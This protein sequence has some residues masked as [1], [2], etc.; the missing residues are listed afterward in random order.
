MKKLYQGLLTMGLVL[1]MA[2]VSLAASA[3]PS[4]AKVMV[5][6]QVVPF[7]AYE[8][9]GFNYFKLTDMSY[10]LTGTKNQ[11]QVTWDGA[12]S[13]INMVSNEPHLVLGTELQG[14]SGKAENAE[15]LG[16][17]VYQDGKAVDCVVYSINGSSYFQLDTL[18]GILD[19]NVGWNGTT[20][21]ITI[22]A[23][24]L[25]SYT[26]TGDTNGDG[27]ISTAEVNAVFTRFRSQYP[28]GTNW[29]NSNS[30][31]TTRRTLNSDGTVSTVGLTAAGCAGWAYML[32][33]AIFG[34]APQYT[35][36]RSQLRPGD[37]W[38]TGS[39]WGVIMSVNSNGSYTTTE[40]N[41]NSS[42]Y[43]DV[44]RTTS[45]LDNSTTYYSRYPS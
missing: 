10:A 16:A 18:K 37:F 19:L 42:I 35:I 36:T 9:Q 45:Y 28:Q 38:Y 20:S 7:G 44:T 32:T 8:I 4:T 5:N 23:D 21:T 29:T 15:L 12:R 39:H 25:P 22:S 27:E 43:W 31:Q 6:G 40:G 11:F 26:L 13:A 41:Y 2:T 3:S 1:S 17:T 14:N 24:P 34:D 30:Y 33:D